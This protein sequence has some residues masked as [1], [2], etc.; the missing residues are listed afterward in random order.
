MKRSFT[1][2]LALAC[3]SG[4]A[5]TRNEWENETLLEQ[6]KEK[7][8][9]PFVLYSNA[10]DA[11]N[12]E[13][14]NSPY[15]QSLN[16]VWKFHYVSK[17]AERPQRFYEEAFDDSK[18]ADLAV[19][20]NWELKGFGIPIYTNIRYPFPA[21]PPFVDNENNPVG[22]Y[23]KTFSIPEN[24]AGR[25]FILNFGSVSGYMVVYVN[26]KRV[27]M[28]KVA[29][30]AAGFNI[31]PHVR[32]GTNVLA[33]EVFRWHDGSYLEDQDF[34][35]LS[36]IERDVSIHALPRL[37][38]WDVSLVAD[39]D[40]KYTTGLF[41]ARV[42]LRRFAGSETIS[43]SVKVELADHSGKTVFT[44][45]RKVNAQQE[46]HSLTFEGRIN[47][48]LRWSAEQPNLYQ[49]TITLLDEKGDVV[50]VTG[51]RTG[52]RKVE[53]RDAQLMVNGVAVLVKGV[54]RHEHDEVLGHVPTADLMRKDV[55]LMKQFN[56]NAV[57]T[58]HYPND[59]YWLKLCDEYGLYV[60]SE[61][62]IESH[63]MGSM[64]WIPDTSRHVAYLPSWVPAHMDRIARLVETGK[65]HPS[66][67]IWS[68]GNECGN[69]AVFHQAYRWIKGRDKTRVVLF[70]QVGED[71]NTD[72]VS[73]MYPSFD[74]MKRYASAPQKRPFIM[75]EYAH[76]MGNSS[77]NFREYWDVIMGSKHMQ[78]GFIWDWVDQGI[79][80]KDENG[81]TYWA[82]GGD[83]GSYHLYNDDNFCANGLVAADRSP[84][85]G[86]YE[87]RK[88]YQNIAFKNRDQESSVITVT[89]WFDFTDLNQFSF[90][91]QLYANG[92]LMAK[93]PFSLSLKPHQ[94]KDVKL[95]LPAITSGE[96]HVLNLLAYTKHGTPLVPSGHTVASEQFIYTPW[97]VKEHDASGE[98]HVKREGDNIVF[99][100]G[101]VQG[102]FNVKEAVFTSY[103]HDGTP[104]L[105]SPPRPYFWRAPVDND[106]GSGMPETLGIWRTAHAHLKLESVDIGE[107]TGG[108]L[109]I[110]VS[111]TLVDIQCPYTVEYTI[112]NDGSIAVRATIDLQGRDVP[113][114]PRFGM[115]MS[116]AAEFNQVQYYGRGPFENYNDRNTASFIGLYNSRVADMFTRNYIRPQENGYRTDVR[117]F[118]LGNGKGKAVR[119]EGTQP[120]CFSAL[121]VMTE[122]LDP[123]LTKKQQH[124]PDVKVR[125]DVWLHVDLRQRG[126]GGDNSWGALPHEQYRLLDKQY[127]YGYRISFTEE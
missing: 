45:S 27:G 69:G 43:G 58:S 101:M 41:N 82:Y 105:T 53:I 117:W 39:L 77:G 50:V 125:D 79:K 71:W 121:N 1:L 2:L 54:N 65:N 44:M 33:V 46:D 38:I 120:L 83:L 16:G 67:I 84:H 22:S 32:K 26:G 62:N 73:P 95:S 111:Y 96:E 57:R 28:S 48:V 97:T 100:A 108:G 3:V 99:S 4:L 47:N 59:P 104:A 87:V 21:N 8:R 76:A 102:R 110:R 31:T 51:A 80:T 127:T 56:I 14:S 60:V 68:M 29:K 109:P 66:I 98:L 86:L 18:W 90:E 5:Q 6:N 37:T 13:P 118:S 122:D 74:Y 93:G 52:F 23:R 78:G 114:L 10:T 55:Q 9:A 34:W 49:C 123:G 91:W 113:E 19:P 15:Y 42:D 7:P 24:W 61:A 85:P 106:F 25:E 20:S 124:I 72:I 107:Q 30:S 112:L 35:R 40:G 64:P 115:R 17:V 81:N 92:K 70:E 103:T 88:V 116:L 36:G 119:I 12:D 89:N 126:V 11:K 63:G 94:S 75:C